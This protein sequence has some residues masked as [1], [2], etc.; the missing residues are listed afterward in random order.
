[1]KLRTKFSLLA[2]FGLAASAFAVQAG[3]INGND[4]TSWRGPE[5]N[6]TSRAKGLIS[7]WANEEENVLW[8]TPLGGR[9]TPIIMDGRIYILRLAGA[10][11]TRQE[12]L[13]CL[14]EKDGSVLWRHQ[15]DMFL[16]DIPDER[17]GWTSPVGDPETGYIYIHGA[18]G[19]L[20]CLDKKGKVVWEHSFTEQ[21]GKI[22][23]FGGRTFTPMIEQDMVVVGFNNSGLGDH[24]KPANRLLALDKKTGEIRW[25]YIPVNQVLDTNY[26]TPVGA[27][28][29]GQ[30]LIIG[31]GGDG[32][33]RAVKANTGER[34]WDYKLIPG[35]INLTP[36]IK[37][38]LVYI[39]YSEENVK[40]E[41]HC[42][43]ATGTGDVSETHKKWS[44]KS[45]VGYSSPAMHDG[46]IYLVE[47][48]GT[49]NC[50]SAENGEIH[51]TLKVGKTA[52]ASPVFADG[53]IYYA[54]VNGEIFVLEPGDKECKVLSK[55]K[56]RSQDGFDMDLT[57]SMAIANGKL[58]FLTRE[59]LYCVGNKDQKVEKIAID[60]PNIPGKGEGAPAWIQ[61]LPA[62]SEIP[63]TGKVNFRALG[64]D[65]KGNPL[66][67]VK[68]EWSLFEDKL[69]GELTANGEFTP[70]ASVVAQFG[71]VEAKVGEVKG[72][73]RLRVMPSLPINTDFEPIPEGLSPVSWVGAGKV[74]FNVVQLDGSKVLQKVK[75]AKILNSYIF[76]TDHKLKNYTLQA[77]VYGDVDEHEVLPN[78]GIINSRYVFDLMGANQ[79]LRIVG[80]VPRPS[81]VV[82]QQ[83]FKWEPKT[84]YT[85][86]CRIDYEGDKATVRGKVWKRGEAEPEAW[87]IELEDP[88][89]YQNGSP[90]LT[91]YP[92]GK[93]A[94]D[95]VK[96]ALNE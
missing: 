88:K 2:A 68:A 71:L 30:R 26:S 15:M 84:W 96:V 79:E 85:M 49:M 66:G 42:I 87:T 35:P 93:V 61:V 60:P 29:N 83:P 38:N 64:F 77:D 31:G 50:V 27:T 19:Y 8:K 10:N 14:S 1:M 74:K 80:W 11:E 18:Q 90:G 25:W 54:A 67:E 65:A 17:V 32:Y 63:K 75:D 58:F 44:I 41:F 56:L 95:N 69:K 76:M 12:E 52:K 62:D 57:G 21:F 5:N 3:P 40:G 59:A 70:D 78:V 82:N 92:I 39:G 28:V 33:V 45:T 55:M 7:S 53:K 94:F 72:S 86:K 51:W 16:S 24:A 81:R 13:V 6:G 47:N 46:R 91:C 20:K 73:A 89:P 4:W 23:G 36:L 48:N 34:V 9:S 43:D 37:D 22:S